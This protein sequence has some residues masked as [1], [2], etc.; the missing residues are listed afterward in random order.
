MLF[1]VLP[2][3]Y[4]YF[5]AAVF[6]LII[7]SFLNVYIYRLHTGKSLAGHSHCMSCGTGLRPYELIPLLSYL[8]LRGRCRTCGCY[9]PIRYFIVELLTGMLFLAAYTIA[10][11][12]PELVYLWSLLSI[13][14]VITIYDIRHFII[15][16]RLTLAL[17]LVTLAWQARLLY[18]GGTLYGLGVTLGAALLGAGF[19]YLLWFVSNG[20]WIGF[21]DVKLAFPLGMMVGPLAVFSMIVFSF[22]IGAGVSLALIGTAKLIGGQF[23]LRNRIFSL[24]IKSVVPFAPFLV[25]GSLLTLFTQINVLSFFSTI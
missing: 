9:I 14:V 5:F 11:S 12:L 25:A 20:R 6:G 16:D 3:A 8:F 4:Q 15:P 23:R 22:W 19:F 13:L 21:G 17:V 1:E 10:S 7:G 18:L 24:T 2:L